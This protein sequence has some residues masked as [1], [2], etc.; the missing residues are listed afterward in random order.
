MV[1]GH[2]QLIVTGSHASG[3]SRYTAKTGYRSEMAWNSSSGAPSGTGMWG[4]ADR[5]AGGRGTSGPDLHLGGDPLRLA[6]AAVDG[7]GQLGRPAVGTRAGEDT[8]LPH[9]GP[10]LAQRR[11]ATGT[12]LLMFAP[13]LGMIPRIGSRY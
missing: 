3:V 11:H 8:H 6:L 12:L 4:R 7:L 1:R 10:L 2:S 9:A 5:S 13:I